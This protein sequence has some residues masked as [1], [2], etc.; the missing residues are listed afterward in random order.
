MHHISTWNL[1]QLFVVDF[2]TLNVCITMGSL[3]LAKPFICGFVYFV[4]LIVN[5]SY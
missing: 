1:N 5:D 4:Y 3:W 2:N